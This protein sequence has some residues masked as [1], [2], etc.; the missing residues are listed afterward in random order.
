ME[1]S[2]RE[3]L[4]KSMAGCAALSL[5]RI[6]FPSLVHAKTTLKIGYLPILDHLSLVVAHARENNMYKH[7]N[8]E[9]RL[10]KSWG[11]VAG[12]LKAGVLDG[13]FLVSSFAM[14][15]FSKGADIRSILVG[16]RNGS[17][18]TVK[19]NAG[20]SSAAGLKGKIIGIP[21]KF[22]THTALLDVYLKKAGLSLKD[23]DVRVIPPPSMIQALKFDR[24]HAFIVAEPF[25]TIAETKGVGK[26]I[27]S[28]H[29]GCYPQS[30]GNVGY[31]LKDLY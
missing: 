1:I 5:G 16:H 3:F 10:M 17:A 15:Q 8:I 25:C 7:I 2:R 4:Q 28:N 22:S 19:K 12:A 31:R 9:P 6:G 24:I 14:H 26:T 20:I 21:A 29:S 11:S 18:I 30:G 23:V 13:S 27:V